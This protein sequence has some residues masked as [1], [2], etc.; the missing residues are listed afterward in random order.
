MP[1]FWPP[2]Q[3]PQPLRSPAQPP[4]SHIFPLVQLHSSKNSSRPSRFLPVGNP[5]LASVPRTHFTLPGPYSQNLGA[6][7]PRAHA[8]TQLG[9]PRPAYVTLPQTGST[10]TDPAVPASGSSSNGLPKRTLRTD[11]M[12]LPGLERGAVPHHA[13]FQKGEKGHL[14]KSRAEESGCH[15][16]KEKQCE[17]GGIF[18]DN[19]QKR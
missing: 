1:N 17:F 7:T 6:S 14:T 12:P 3:T 5:G 2:K 10:D 18:Y 15:P 11:A 16:T 4:A 13:G 9:D 8:L 19:Q